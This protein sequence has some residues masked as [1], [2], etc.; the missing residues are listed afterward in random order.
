MVVMAREAQLTHIVGA[1]DPGGGT[2]GRLNGGHQKAQQDSD[3]G[4]HYYQFYKAKP[5]PASAHAI[6]HGLSLCGCELGQ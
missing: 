2:T 5:A 1:G 4:H 6:I 3:D